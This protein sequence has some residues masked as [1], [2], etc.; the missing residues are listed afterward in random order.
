[1]EKSN[2]IATR[3]EY[4]SSWWIVIKLL[5][6]RRKWATG[7]IYILTKKNLVDKKTDLV[8][9][10]IVVMKPLFSFVFLPHWNWYCCY[11]RCRYCRCVSS[12]NVNVLSLFQMVISYRIVSY[13]I[14]FISLPPVTLVIEHIVC[15]RWVSNQV[16]LFGSS[17]KHLTCWILNMSSRCVLHPPLSLTLSHRSSWNVIFIWRFTR[18]SH[19][20]LAISWKLPMR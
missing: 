6:F 8:N 4:G 9:V 17:S 11:Y 7:N 18:K 1:M 16:Q 13:G 15:Q 2:C 19:A 3:W 12:Q 20:K 10:S 5:E 14:Q